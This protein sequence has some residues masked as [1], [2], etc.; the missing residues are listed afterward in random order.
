MTAYTL[1]TVVVRLEKGRPSKVE[2][3]QGA[4]HFAARFSAKS[5]LV[6]KRGN[7]LLKLLITF[8]TSVMP[9]ALIEQSLS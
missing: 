4:F 3:M 5:R 2:A 8:P 9:H 6:P 7:A 1:C